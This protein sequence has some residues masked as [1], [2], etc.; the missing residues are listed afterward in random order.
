MRKAD[1]SPGCSRS[2]L[3]EKIAQVLSI[4]VY[5]A[6]PYLLLATKRGLVKKTVLPAY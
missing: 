6:A 3:D 5:S 4:R 2:C 1:M